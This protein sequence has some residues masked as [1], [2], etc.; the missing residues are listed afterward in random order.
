MVAKQKKKNYLLDYIES[1]QKKRIYYITKKETLED[2]NVNQINFNAASRL[3]GKKNK[4]YKIHPNFY[5]IVPLEYQDEKCPPPSLFFDSFMAFLGQDYYVSLLSAVAFYEENLMTEPDFQIMITKL[6]RPIHTPSYTIQYFTKKHWPSVGIVRVNTS[7]GFL[8]I[9]SPEL[10]AFDLVKYIYATGGDKNLK[11]A[12]KSFAK[13]IRSDQL[14]ELA[15]KMKSARAEIIH[16]QRL[17]YLLDEMGEIDLTAPLAQWIKATNPK[18]GYLNPPK[19]D[20]PIINE[21]KNIKWKLLI[22]KNQ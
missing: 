17:G 15:E 3:L 1:R 16:W 14:A 12:L 7:Y 10:T 18:S 5:I 21:E 8:N 6:R 19:A 11:K 4:L 2:V 22:N 9:S 13:K 20:K